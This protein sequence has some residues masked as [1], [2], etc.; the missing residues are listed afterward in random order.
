VTEA[1]AFRDLI[2]RVRSGDARAAEE[3]VRRYEPAIRLAVRVRLTDPALRRR[4]DS[5]DICNSVLANFFVRAAAGQFELEQPA[6]LLRLL[7]T[8]ARHHVT[9]LALKHHAARRDCRRL[10]RG[11]PDA[12]TF[13]DPGPSPSQVVAHR[14]LVEAVRQK[15]S[16]DERR[17]AEQRALG[18]SWAEIA[19]DVG[20]RPDA[21]RMRLARAL[22]RV[23]A[24][25]GLPELVTR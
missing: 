4:L 10:Q 14:E 18:R 24:E 13:V 20:G 3:L 23:V 1:N 8:M 16:P 2:V 21:L 6:Q 11:E 19:A 17:L 22:D 9:N 7:T 15:L 5:T 25:L 12:E